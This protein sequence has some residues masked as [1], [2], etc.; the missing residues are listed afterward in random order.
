MLLGWCPACWRW[1]LPTSR[2]VPA[3]LWQT[4]PN[5]VLTELPV[6]DSNNLSM[7]RGRKYLVS[8]DCTAW[9]QSILVGTGWQAT[10]LLCRYRMC[11]V[12]AA[13]L[14]AL[15]DGLPVPGSAGQQQA[16]EAV[17]ASLR[18]P[19]AAQRSL[20]AGALQAEAAAVVTTEMAS[21]GVLGADQLMPAQQAGTDS[22]QAGWAPDGAASSAPLLIKAAW[23]PES[24]SEDSAVLQSPSVAAISQLA[25][26]G[27]GPV[28]LL[29]KDV[30][31]TGAPAVQGLQQCLNPHSVTADCWPAHA[32]SLEPPDGSV[33]EDRPQLLDCCTA[34]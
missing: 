14:Q 19:F 13:G 6:P 17:A 1:Q 9:V 12:V 10:Q 26:Q 34:R 16:L 33:Q 28:M 29:N 3:S 15:R 31:G 25:L 2:S 32:G 27:R 30:G 20:V 4:R 22:S 8:A 5:L 18:R 11:R 24:N 21:I 23:S 7:R